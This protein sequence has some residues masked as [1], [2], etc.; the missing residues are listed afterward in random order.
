MENLIRDNLKRVISNIEKAKSRSLY[1]QDVTLVAVSKTVD[2]EKVIEVSRLGILNFGENK[3]QELVKK[4]DVMPNLSW[5]QIGTLQKNKVKYI[6]DKV[7]MIHSLD[8]IS[9]AEMIDKKAKEK[10]IVVDCLLQINIS[11]EKTK[12]GILK[13]GAFDFVKRVE[14]SFANIRLRGLMA[15]A[16]YE[17]EASKT[18]PYFRQMKE[19]IE[20]INSKNIC[21]KKL[22]TLSMGMSNDYEIA[23]EEGATIV[24]VGSSIFGERIYI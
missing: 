9:L 20:E 2:I 3:P 22:D 4:Y 18:R 21:C 6:F 14:D 11:N 5:H 24:R 8:S 19:L 12:H 15:M 13:E 7:K 23:I 16:P 10:N 17:Q 1:K